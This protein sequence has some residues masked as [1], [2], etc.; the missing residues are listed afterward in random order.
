MGLPIGQNLVRAGLTVRAWNRS[1]DKA[2]PLAQAGATVAETPGDAVSGADVVLTM[3]FDQDSVAEVI[4]QARGRF[5]PGVTWIQLSTV[6]VDGAEQLGRLAADLGLAYVDAPVLGTKKPAEDS[7]LTVLA[8]GPDEAHDTCAPVF[9]AI[10]ART[11]WVGPAGQGSR[12]KLVANAWV[13]S[14]L[15]GIAESLTL[16]RELGLDPS[17][18]LQAVAGGAMD[19][20]YVQLKGKAMLDGAF[21]PAFAL[22]GAAKDAGLILAAAEQAGTTMPIA[23]IAQRYMR[24]AE[25]EGYGDKDMAAIYLA[26]RSSKNG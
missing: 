25:D 23:S 19:A 21:E 22:S 6:G 1:S 4:E 7:A 2:D 5:A 3:L 12:L 13:L 24:Q 16:A 15:E 26:D 20:P 9:E 18:F 8:S 14:V 17:L 11:L 10:A